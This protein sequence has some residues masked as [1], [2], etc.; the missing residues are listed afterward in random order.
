MPRRA[1]MLAIAEWLGV[2]VEWLEYGEGDKRPGASY[3]VQVKEEPAGAE[4]KQKA[5][6]LIGLAT[7][8]SR[9]ALERI[10]SA[11]EAGRLS[12]EDLLLLERIAARFERDG[13]HDDPA[14]STG[15]NTRLRERLRKDDS[16]PQQ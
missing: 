14:P 3:T 8:R 16:N 15:S 6:A 1:N 5:E 7:P 12:E 13:T 10:A 4:A 11:A 2:R 9:T